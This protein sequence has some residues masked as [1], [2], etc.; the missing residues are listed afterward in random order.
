[1][2]FEETRMYAQLF[3]SAITFA[4]LPESFSTL[5]HFQDANV[6]PLSGRRARVNNTPVERAR[7]SL[8][9][10]DAGI[11]EFYHIWQNIG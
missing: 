7:G 8:Y 3:K 1:M 5:P 2:I 9:F 6:S 10:S 11:F 4:T